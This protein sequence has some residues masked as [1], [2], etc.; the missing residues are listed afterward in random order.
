[1]GVTRSL[2]A[3]RSYSAAAALRVPF[4]TNGRLR[5][6][7][8]QPRSSRGS[9]ASVDSQF[10][11]DPHASRGATGD[12][13]WLAPLVRLLPIGAAA[14]VDHQGHMELGDAGHA[15]REL[16]F[17]AIEMVY[18]RFEHQLIVNLQD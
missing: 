6:M 9:A 5:I 11:V 17:H 18:G 4:L 7:S 12:A 15:Q 16:G 3:T 13:G 10:P 14:D 8:G 2:R 1:M